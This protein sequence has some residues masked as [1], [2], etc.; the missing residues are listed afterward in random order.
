MSLPTINENNFAQIAQMT[1]SFPASLLHFCVKLFTK[2]VT[3]DK[4]NPLISLNKFIRFIRY[5]R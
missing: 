1:L 5:P 4:Q 3:K 2:E